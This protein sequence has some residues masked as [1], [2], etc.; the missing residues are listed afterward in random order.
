NGLD[1]LHY[2]DMPGLAQH[3]RSLGYCRVYYSELLTANS[4]VEE[5]QQVARQDSQARFVLIGYSFGANWARNIAHTLADQGIAIDLL[6]YLNANTLRNT[7]Y[8]RP[9]NAQRVINILAW[10]VLLD[11]DH[12]DN[13][14]NIEITDAWHFNTPM[15]PHTLRILEQELARLHDPRPITTPK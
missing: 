6:V 13:A 11:G 7:P 14:E 10:G 1:L 8:D 2:A 5:I 3:L 15:H 9:E 12:L 4:L